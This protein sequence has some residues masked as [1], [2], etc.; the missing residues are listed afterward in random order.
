MAGTAC[1][2]DTA[3]LPVP[4]FGKIVDMAG[5][6]ERPD[7]KLHYR[8]VFAVTKTGAI[9]QTIRVPSRA[10]D[11]P[12]DLQHHRLFIPGGDGAMGIYDVSN[13][14]AVRELG[15]LSMPRDARTALLFRNGVS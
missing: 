15:K 13:P 5:A 10:D 8:I 9:T 12:F 7:P 2:A 3:P 4:D 1:A 14:D 11:L 6:Q